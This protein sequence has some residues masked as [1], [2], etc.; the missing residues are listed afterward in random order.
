MIWDGKQIKRD[1]KSILPIHIYLLYPWNICIIHDHLCLLC[2][3]TVS[4]VYMNVNMFAEPQCLHYQHVQTLRC[5]VEQNLHLID[6]DQCIICSRTLIQ[7]RFKVK[8]NKPLRCVPLL[9]WSQ[10]SFHRPVEYVNARIQAVSYHLYSL[11][12]IGKHRRHNMKTSPQDSK[13][14]TF[15]PLTA[16]SKPR[17]TWWEHQLKDGFI[18]SQ[19]KLEVSRNRWRAM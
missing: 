15:N 1:N 19:G 2:I 7:A 14:P 11:L 5:T 12:L 9:G 18:A 10:S 17:T 4:H 16:L 6:S 8:K 3:H 13:L